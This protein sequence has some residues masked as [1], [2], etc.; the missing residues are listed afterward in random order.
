MPSYV[1][2]TGS[3]VAMAL[4]SNQTLFMMYHTNSYANNSVLLRSPKPMIMRDIFLTRANSFFPN[5]LSCLYVANPTDCV[6]NCAAAWLLAKPIAEVIGWRQAMVVYC[7]SGFFS[8]FAYLFATQINPSKINT[9]YDCNATSNGAYA[10]LA[11]LSLL[12]PKCYLP[13]S[14]RTPIAWV[15]GPY[16]AK[17]VYDEYIAPKWVERRVEDYTELRNWGFVGGVFFTL[18]YSSLCLGTRRD[19]KLATLFYQNLQRK[20]ASAP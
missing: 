9:E 8:S 3:L 10:G 15:G 14:K 19:L 16:L 13:Y 4:M 20:T 7:G 6:T 2:I 5:P 11:T 12:L 1:Q 17:C 18:I